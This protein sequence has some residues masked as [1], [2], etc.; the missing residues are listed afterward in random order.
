MNTRCLILIAVVLSSILGASSST[1]QSYFNDPCR[2]ASFQA[3]DGQRKLDRASDQ[4][5]R[6]NALFASAQERVD[7][8]LA[9]LQT[10][11]DVAN[12]D[13]RAASQIATVETTTCVVGWYFWYRYSYNCVNRTVSSGMSRRSRA[14]ANYNAAVARKKSYSVY[15]QGYLRRQAL[16][17]EDAQNQFNLALTT[18]DT[19]QARYSECRT[20]NPCPLVS[21][22]GRCY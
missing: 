8:Q 1:A 4:L 12:S 5:L 20:S 9:S 7:R 3:G 18:R 15:A 22:Y 2:T 14:Q 10:A 17:V 6:A 13:R 19:A 16:R 21:Y 11:I